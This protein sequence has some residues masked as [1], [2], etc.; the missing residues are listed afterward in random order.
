MRVL[1]SFLAWSFLGLVLAAYAIAAVLTGPYAWDD[2]AITVAFARTLAESGQFALTA[3][4]ER[5]E[6]TSSILFTLILSLIY[7]LKSFSFSGYIHVSQALAWV[8]LLATVLL[9]R[10]RLSDIG[11]PATASLWICGLFALVPLHGSEILNGMEMTGFGFLLLAFVITYERQS[12]A[13]LALIPLLLLIRFEA[14]FY[15]GLACAALFVLDPLNRALHLRALVVTVA[16][17]AIFTLIRWVYFA[18]FLPNT[19]WAKMQ[20]PYTRAEGLGE[21][22]SEKSDGLVQFCQVYGGLI[23]ILL[24]LLVI[25]RKSNALRDLKLWLVIG[26]ALFAFVSGKAWGYDGR[27]FVA[28]L[29]VFLLTLLDRLP[30]NGTASLTGLAVLALVLTAITTQ[31]QFSRLENLVKLGAVRQG[32]IADPDQKIVSPHRAFHKIVNPANYRQIGQHA[33]E[34]RVLMG[35]ET[36][37]FMAPDAG[38]LG[39]CCDPNS[40]EMLDSAL[41]TNRHLAKTGYAG[42]ESYFNAMQPDLL[43]AHGV[44]ARAPGFYERPM[45]PNRYDPVIYKDTLF[46]VRKD[47]ITQMAENGVEFA[48]EPWSADLIDLRNDFRAVDVDYLKSDPAFRLQR[49]KLAG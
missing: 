42:F 8:F 28:V 14:V 21:T 3:A 7:W 20:Y 27:M 23:I 9:L 31:N 11:I 41:L 46:W 15:L 38:G 35:L 19:V 24:T 13:A 25:F 44:W 45:L 36:V 5:V 34:L 33:D 6:G 10:T 30:R 32:Y 37:R 48:D 40:I 43:V 29:P 18:D 26:F 17:F 16:S 39:L 47:R 4:S 12:I 49:I 2:G 1:N 22:L